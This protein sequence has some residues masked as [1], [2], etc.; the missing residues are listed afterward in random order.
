MPWVR[1]FSFIGEWCVK[2]W[3]SEH[4]ISYYIR[5]FSTLPSVNMVFIGPLFYFL[6]WK[7]QPELPKEMEC[8]L[9]RSLHSML[10]S[11]FS[12]NFL[13][14]NIKSSTLVTPSTCM[15]FIKESQHCTV[16]GTPR[17]V[18]LVWRCLLLTFCAFALRVW[19]KTF[20]C[21]PLVAPC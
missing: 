3:N 12:N 4:Y 1:L 18:L 17:S 15:P 2:I 9:A 11:I 7:G 8:H 16:L 19:M 10:Q 21:L 13:F 20:S 6:F 5:T 14:W